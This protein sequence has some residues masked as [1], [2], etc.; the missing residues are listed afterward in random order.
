MHFRRGDRDVLVVFNGQ[1]DAAVPVVEWPGRGAGRSWVLAPLRAPV[2]ARRGGR[3]PY[4][5]F[6]VTEW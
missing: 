3:V 1:T 5:G 4:Q 6:L 2:P